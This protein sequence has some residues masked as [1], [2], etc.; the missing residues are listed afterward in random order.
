MSFKQLAEDLHKL[1]VEFDRRDAE[2]EEFRLL[3]LELGKVEAIG[4]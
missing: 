2:L 4:A 3:L 1:N